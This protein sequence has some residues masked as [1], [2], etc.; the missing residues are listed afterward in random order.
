MPTPQST[1]NIISAFGAAQYTW[2]ALGREFLHGFYNYDACK[3]FVN[4]RIVGNLRPP[5][6]VD[7]HPCRPLDFGEKGQ[8]CYSVSL[9]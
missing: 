4:G 9:H 1:S 8:F 3:A 5:A 6:V 7:W 2:N